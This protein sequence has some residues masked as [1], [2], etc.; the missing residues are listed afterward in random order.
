MRSRPAPKL[1]RSAISRFRRRRARQQEIGDI[2]ASDTENEA[3]QRQQDVQRLRISPPQAVEAARAFPYNQSG[4]VLRPA[5]RV[6]AACPFGERA[7]QRR[8]CLL[9]ADPGTQTRHGHNPV[10]HRVQVSLG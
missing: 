2:R 9:R 6:R 3:H 1:S 10:V 7:G 5:L 8:L 4:H